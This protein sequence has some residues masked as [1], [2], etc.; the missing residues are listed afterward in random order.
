MQKGR[1]GLGGLLES[2]LDSHSEHQHTTNDEV[3]LG[4]Q[5]FVLIG[6][7]SGREPFAEIRIDLKR[8]ADAFV[9][10][11]RGDVLVGRQ[12]VLHRMILRRLRGGCF[13]LILVPVEGLRV[14]VESK[15]EVLP[16]AVS[17]RVEA[18]GLGRENASHVICPCLTD[19]ENASWHESLEADVPGV[20]DQRLGII[21]PV[22]GAQRG[23]VSP[24]VVKQGDRQ[25][26]EAR[27]HP[28]RQLISMLLGEGMLHLDLS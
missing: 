28:V 12:H 8:D 3:F 20:L 5:A 21:Q 7:A 11:S 26:A 13:V 25:G 24:R 2:P 1:G 4:K 19:N 6:V 22:Q 27:R 14:R 16:G 18:P 10:A 15:D 23:P 17:P 9:V